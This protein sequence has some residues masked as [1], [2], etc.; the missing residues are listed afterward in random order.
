VSPHLAVM[1]LRLVWFDPS[2]IAAGSESVARAEAAAVFGRMGATVSWR[3]GTPG[4]I[5]QDGETWVTVIGAGPKQVSSRL[6]LGATLGDHQSSVVWVREPNVRAVLGISRMRSAAALT[7]V[8]RHALAVALGRVI[9]HEVV[10]V[11]VPSLPHG[12]GL[13]AA[14]L[15][16]RQLTAATISFEPDVAFALQAALRSEPGTAPVRMGVVAAAAARETGH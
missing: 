10:H 1:V 5:I 14:T 15:S 6:V 13:M 4:E 2:D 16:R 12:R 8:E 7:P 3:R 11:R 9:A